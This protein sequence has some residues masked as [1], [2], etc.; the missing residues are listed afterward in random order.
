MFNR[1]MCQERICKRVIKAAFDIEA[2]TIEYLNAEQC[3][4]PSPDNRGV[5]MDV[6][7]KTSGRTFDLEVQV[8]KEKYLGKRMR[9]YQATLDGSDLE[10]GA[11]HRGL[12][13]TFILFICCIDPFGLGLPVYTI[14]RT[15]LEAPELAVGND[16]HWMALNARAWARAADSELGDL[17]NYV[18]TGSAT[19]SLSRDIDEL[20]A[21]Y[22]EDRKWVNRV[23]TLE[24]E[25]AFREQERWEEGREEGREGM[26]LEQIEK[27]RAKGKSVEKIAEELEADIEIIDALLK[28]YQGR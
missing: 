20:V 12:R 26:L 19:G 11:H 24:Q 2:D 13:E 3:Y 4:E 22:N 1:V 7:A 25:M 28:K 27:K 18:E 21:S 14:E 6:V 5:R 9:F 16:S 15:C 10:R 23:Y 8:A 17:L